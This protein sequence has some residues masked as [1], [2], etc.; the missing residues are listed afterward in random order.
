V[1]A[2]TAG[3]TRGGSARS[4]AGRY[5]IATIID[6]L[7]LARHPPLVSGHR[8][9]HAIRHR[10]SEAQANIMLTA[11][12][13]GKRIDAEAHRSEELAEILKQL[14]ADEGVNVDV[15]VNGDAVSLTQL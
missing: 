5:E 9:W 12:Q 11:A 15:T 1:L 2:F 7:A 3:L 8:P 6:T 4:P 10:S 14:A 13:S